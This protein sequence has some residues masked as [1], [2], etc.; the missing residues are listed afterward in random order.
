MTDLPFLVEFEGDLWMLMADDDQRSYIPILDT[1]AYRLDRG[2]F[3]WVQRTGFKSS[4]A[5]KDLP[6]HT[7]VWP[8]PEEKTP[9]AAT[10][11]CTE[12]TVPCGFASCEVHYS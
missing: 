10:V 7:V 8:R 1:H 3:V 9:F 11:H 5:L 6:G 2:N 4:L 12:T